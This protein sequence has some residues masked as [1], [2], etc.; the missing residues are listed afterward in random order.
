MDGLTIWH[1]AR[2]TLLLLQARLRF[3]QFLGIR[4]ARASRLQYEI[5]QMK[6]RR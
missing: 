5:D 4:D 1:H 6:A 2:M 3:R